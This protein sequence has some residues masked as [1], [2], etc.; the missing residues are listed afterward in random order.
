MIKNVSKGVIWYLNQLWWI[1]KRLLYV[2]LKRICEILPPR[3]ACNL[4][5]LY[6]R[7]TRRPS[8]FAYEPDTGLYTA[9]DK[10]HVH[11][12]AERM[13]GFWLY[14]GGIGE[15]GISIFESYFLQHVD[16]SQGDLII[17]CGA[18]YADL[19]IHL[20]ET[21]A[22]I[23][24]V[25]FEPSRKE[26]DCVKKNAPGN[27][28]HNMALSNQ[29]EEIDLYVSSRGADSSIFEPRQ[30]YSDKISIE[31]VSLNKFAKDIP[32]IKL[33]KLEA[34]G[35]EPEILQGASEVLHKIE[36]IAADGGAERGVKE[37]STVESI[38]NALL[39]RGFVLLHM[40]IES[41]KG[42]ALYKN[43]DFSTEQY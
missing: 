9:K 6:Q 14:S 40:D 20:N 3:S 31:A 29:C 30:G 42:R 32:R 16:F 38:T 35:A 1:H 2:S 5:N 4:F 39:G 27:E 21:V 25:S 10:K 19:Y 41:G 7:L 34:E 13:R 11:Y 23:R 33:L 22:D 15:R 28:H 37:E 12:F 26:F 43:C 24:Y 36:Y 18:N 8:L 17:D